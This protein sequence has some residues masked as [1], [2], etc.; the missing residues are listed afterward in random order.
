LL[1]NTHW[2]LCSLSQIRE[3]FAFQQ[4]NAC[5]GQQRYFSK[6]LGACLIEVGNKQ[7]H[8]CL[9][10]EIV[11]HSQQLQAI[12]NQP[13][14][15]DGTKEEQNHVIGTYEAYSLVE[16][17]INDNGGQRPVERFIMAETRLSGE[18]PD[19]D[20]NSASCRMGLAMLAKKTMATC[21]G[22]LC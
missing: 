3:C 11:L 12:Y 18:R 22:S 2:Q 13:E 8:A 15:M 14:A 19:I 9:L 4:S 10:A 21:E 1:I 20:A 5:R 6:F 16:F 17:T 7:T